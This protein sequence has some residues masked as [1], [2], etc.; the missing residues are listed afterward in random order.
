MLW[1]LVT[2]LSDVLAVIGLGTVIWAV[3]RTTRRL[4]RLIGR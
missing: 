1:A 4:S 2:R 3:V